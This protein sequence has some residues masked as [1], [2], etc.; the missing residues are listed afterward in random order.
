MFKKFKLRYIFLRLHI[1]KCK[2]FFIKNGKISCTFCQ[3]LSYF[4]V[5]NN[6][7]NEYKCIQHYA[8]REKV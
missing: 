6:I 8:K 1:K 5:F 4:G 3:I 7:K 2:I